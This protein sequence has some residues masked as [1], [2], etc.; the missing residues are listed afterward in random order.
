[1]TLLY[2]DPLFLEHETG[3]HPECPERLRRV[4][5]GLKDSK[6]VE[7]CVTPEWKPIGAKQLALIHDASYVTTVK[8]FA[9]SGGGRIESDTVVSEKSYDVACL[10]TGAICDAT[11]KVLSGKDSNAFCAVRPPGHHAVRRGPM[12]FCLFN[13]IAVAAA[14]AIDQH[15]LD[16]VMIIDWDVHHGNG[17]QD[18]FW[19]NEQVGFMSIHR[20]P[21]YPGSG[22][23]RETGKGKGLGYTLN[24][25]VKAG[26][27]RDQYHKAFVKG[28]SE[29]AE[30]VKPQLILLSA[31]FDSHRADPIGSLGL[32]VED[33]VTLSKHV[34]ALANSHCKGKLVSILEGGYNVDVLPECV[35]VHLK[36][37]LAASDKAKGPSPKD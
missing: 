17:T 33:F 21:F 18:A 3:S 31:G 35:E 15:K 12:G 9:A 16:R 20:Y 1:M 28:T 26:T 29:L 23:E 5:K 24:V 13:S 14:V 37:L 4:S 6:L 30:K 22:A 36:E 25:P 27:S 2:Q 10:A 34:I 19:E 8:E 7:E 11:E 32:E